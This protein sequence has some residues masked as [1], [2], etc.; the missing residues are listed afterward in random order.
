VAGRN[1]F[2]APV[3][4]DGR[5]IGGWRRVL[6]EETVSITLDLPGRLARAD[7]R[8]VEEAARRYG[9]FLG[10]DAMARVR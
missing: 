2:A 6:G 1:P 10:L 7:A 3:V 5:V 9:D 8:L 4:L